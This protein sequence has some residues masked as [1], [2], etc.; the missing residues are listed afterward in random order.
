MAAGAAPG[1]LAAPAGDALEIVSVRRRRGQAPGGISDRR[2]TKDT[3]SALSRALGGEVGH[4]ASACLHPAG[5]RR[6]EVH[7]PAPQRQAARTQRVRVER[8]APLLFDVGPA[9]EVATEEY[10]PDI[11][12]QAARSA[13]RVPQCRSELDL[14][15]P[16]AVD[17]ARDG[18]E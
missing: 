16:R 13:S 11:A 5:L 7:D 3:G 2:Q 8:Q 4:D 12:F 1:Q 14:V 10:G 15:D 6:E 17:G 18:E 9:A